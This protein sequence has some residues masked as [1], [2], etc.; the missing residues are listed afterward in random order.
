VRLAAL[1]FAILCWP[2][3]ASAQAPPPTPEGPLPLDQTQQTA[4]AQDWAAVHAQSTFVAQDHPGFPAAF[5]G[6][7]SLTPT[8][9][10]RETSDVTVYL[11]LRPWQG[12]EL[13]ANP[14]MDQGFGLSNTLGVA[15]FP[16][17]EDYKVGA[18]NPYGRLP[19]LFFRQTIDLGGEA[20]PVAGAANQFA[21]SQTADR[22]VLTVGKFAVTDIF[23]ANQYAHDA[24]GDFFNWSVIDAGTFDYAADAWGF[25]YGGAAEWYQD[26][27]T[28]RSGVFDLSRTPNDKALDTHF[29]AQYQLDEEVEE[30]H[31]LF[32]EAGS[33]KFLAYLT[34][35]RMGQ[36][37]EATAIA[38]ATGTPANIEAVRATHNKAGFSFN[39]Q[40]ALA[41]DLGVFARAGY[42]QGQ[43]E[44]FDFTDIDKTAS[45]GLS[46]S[47]TR[48]DRPDDTVGLAAVVNNAS[49]AAKRFL[50]AGGL[51]ILAGDGA[52]LHSGPEGILEAYYSLAAFSFAKLTADYQFIVNP[53]YNADRGPVSVF[54]VRLH[55]QF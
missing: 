12:G 28:I 40:Q 7:N 54:G 49:G 11:G 51:G 3:L 25:T 50:A 16:S 14:E 35:G 34:H 36:Y 39:L 37:D 47:G 17:G 20:Q 29:F 32:G 30:R 5:S 6:P 8:N 48:W 23:D 33:L 26:W 22:L 24:R 19:R 42:M 27:W 41:D 45:A 9:Q 53:A 10:A 55:A 31:T 46:L 1:A 4:S 15:G 2:A 18:W 52:L 38:L 21:G 43:Y 44:A 13:W